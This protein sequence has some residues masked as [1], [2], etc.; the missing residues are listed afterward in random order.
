[1]LPLVLLTTAPAFGADLGLGVL[2]GYRGLDYRIGNSVL[3][4]HFF[5]QAVR[6]ELAEHAAKFDVLPRRNLLL[7]L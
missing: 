1:M 6:V 4:E 7:V 2:A 5:E 3:Q